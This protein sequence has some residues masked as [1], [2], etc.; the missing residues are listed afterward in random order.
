MI[1]FFQYSLIEAVIQF[2]ALDIR[3]NLSTVMDGERLHRFLPISV[4]LLDTDV[5]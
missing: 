1:L 3:L 2:R 4:K 5:F